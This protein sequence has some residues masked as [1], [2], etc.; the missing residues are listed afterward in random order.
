M[1]AT[2][3]RNSTIDAQVTTSISAVRSAWT[4]RIAGAMRQATASSASRT[5]VSRTRRSGAG[6]SSVR[7]EG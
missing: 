6:S 5:R 4:I 3:S 1:R 2:T 7:I